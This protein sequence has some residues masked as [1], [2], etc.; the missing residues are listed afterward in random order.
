MQKSLKYFAE[1]EPNSQLPVLFPFDCS[2]SRCILVELKA[3]LTCVVF[4]CKHELTRN[5]CGFNAMHSFASARAS[6]NFFKL[7]KAKQRL[8]R[9]ADI[10]SLFDCGVSSIAR[11]QYLAIKSNSFSLYSSFPPALPQCSLFDLSE[12]KICLTGKTHLL[13]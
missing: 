4:K 3:P 9:S 2:E 13:Q 5:H 12:D 7:I 11:L 10:S 1:T 6:F 8:L